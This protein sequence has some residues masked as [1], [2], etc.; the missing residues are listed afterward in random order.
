MLSSVMLKQEKLMHKKTAAVAAALLLSIYL[1]QPIIRII[2]KG[3]NISAATIQP[4][5]SI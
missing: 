4:P 1:F 2:S 5:N 3:I